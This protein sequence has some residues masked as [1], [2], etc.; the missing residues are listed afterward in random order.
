MQRGIMAAWRGNAGAGEKPAARWRWRVKHLAPARQPG[1]A[2]AACAPWRQKGKMANAQPAAASAI[3]GIE[4]GATAVSG[5][6]RK[7]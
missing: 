2:I 7:A 1:G 5:G 3:S 6:E 4:N